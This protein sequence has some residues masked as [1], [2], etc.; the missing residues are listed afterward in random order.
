ME[1]RKEPPGLR[2]TVA[3]DS[4]FCQQDPRLRQGPLAH[5]P[6]PA[7]THRVF[8]VHQP[9]G[10]THP[11]PVP[12]TGLGGLTNPPPASPACLPDHRPCPAASKLLRC[13]Y[14]GRGPAI[15]RPHPHPSF[16]TSPL[17]SAHPLCPSDPWAGGRP[18]AANTSEHLAAVG[19]EE[20]S[21]SSHPHPVPHGGGCVPP[22][23]RR[24]SV[25]SLR[26]G[27]CSAEGRNA[28]LPHAKQKRRPGARA[29]RVPQGGPAIVT[30]G[31]SS[32]RK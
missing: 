30:S 27:H 20:E 23:R 4:K 21:A 3:T 19:P 16:C 5:H 31:L 24:Q 22:P 26:T 1:E 25:C 2:P 7:R 18:I 11:D 8:L 6:H 32:Y 15:S 10:P 29:G 13:L 9:Q 14:Q 12:P 17:A 28:H